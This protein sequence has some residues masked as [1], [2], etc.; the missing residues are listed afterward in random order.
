MGYAAPGDYLNYLIYVPETRYYTMYFRV[1]TIR[2][3]N[4]LIIRVGEGNSF[5]SADTVSFNSTGGWQTWQTVPT[6]VLL[7]E[8]RYT[9]R[10]YVR[11][12]EFN[13][14]WFQA[15]SGPLVGIGAQNRNGLNIYP[16]PASDF[17]V[18]DFNGAD[19]GKKEII[20][21]N[22]LGQVVKNIQSNETSKTRINISGLKNGIYYIEVRNKNTAVKTIKQIIQQH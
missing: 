10:M 1:A 4:Q 5:T 12:G 22:S 18:V 6:T 17:I 8:G 16:N 11:S 2:S 20:I 15:I 13:T 7:E 3:N 19:L 14:N 21:C 9:V